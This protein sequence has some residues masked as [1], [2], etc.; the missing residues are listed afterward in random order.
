MVGWYTRDSRLES[1]E[2]NKSNSISKCCALAKI[3]LTF[4]CKENRP[5]ASIF[6][7][8]NVKFKELNKLMKTVACL[9]G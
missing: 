1:F 9:P 3:F 4:S 8:V 5:T 2:A 7:T 6:K